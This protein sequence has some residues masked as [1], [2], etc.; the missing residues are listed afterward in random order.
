MKYYRLPLRTPEVKGISFQKRKD[1]TYVL[2]KHTEHETEPEEKDVVRTSV[3]GKLV[4]EHK[5]FFYPND[6]YRRL[7]PDNGLVD[8]LAFPDE[9][10]FSPGLFVFLK[11]TAEECGLYDKL[12]ASF[13]EET[14]P[15]ILDL[16][17]YLVS[18]ASH[19]AD[20][21]EYIKDSPL[22][23]DEWH[24][25]EDII[26]GIREKIQIR[27][28]RGFVK[29]WA[30]SQEQEDGE[31]PDVYLYL[32]TSFWGRLFRGRFSL[33]GSE[34][35]L[36][37][38]VEGPKGF[39]P[40]LN[41]ILALRCPDGM[42]LFYKDTGY[43]A[44]VNI[45]DAGADLARKHR[46]KRFTYLLKDPD[47]TDEALAKLDG[48][49]YDYLFHVR[50]D[51]AKCEECFSTANE[52]ELFYKEVEGENHEFVVAYGY[53][54]EPFTLCAEVETTYGS[55][56][57]WMY[58]YYNMNDVQ[59][60]EETVDHEVSWRKD[61]A[62]E[63]I[64]KTREELEK[65]GNIPEDIEYY[66]FT[67]GKKDGKEVVTGY[68]VDEDAVERGKYLAGVTCYFTTTGGMAEHAPGFVDDSGYYSSIIESNGLNT[69]DFIS[70][71]SRDEDLDLC[72]KNKN[73][74]IE[75]FI[76]FVACILL[77][78]VQAAAEKA[79][80]TEY[81]DSMLSLY[82]ALSELTRICATRRT[83]GKFRLDL[84]LDYVQ[85]EL[86]KAVGM[87]AEDFVQEMEEAGENYFRRNSY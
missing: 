78:T 79:G 87:S 19:M 73:N 55:R 86:F 59:G 49:G 63:C 65:T 12:R 60:E 20:L 15:V 37:P 17:I 23:T 33:S 72:W 53:V 14:V 42:P 77:H 3:I 39:L 69:R 6:N 46:A 61:L 67:W 4:L 45:Y 16:A 29:D 26:K 51:P 81:D 22:M 30:A 80:L 66:K 8:D 56:K 18:Y 21:D 41:Y 10:E 75:S 71:L 64:G 85:T 40:E 11:R 74:E 31:K 27:Q 50:D 68:E 82:S 84:P 47:V 58:V 28:I 83:R 13:D 62:E 7:F 52:Y 2:Y 44:S 76:K 70:Q 38:D 35:R 24:N 1:G 25:A 43:D 32:D 34:A 48:A 36:R 9:Y 54:R 5:L 57:G